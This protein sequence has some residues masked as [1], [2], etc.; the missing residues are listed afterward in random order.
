VVVVHISIRSSEQLNKIRT[1][2]LRWGLDAWPS[3]AREC[4]RGR[5]LKVKGVCY[6][7]MPGRIKVQPTVAVP[8]AAARCSPRPTG[9]TG[10]EPRAA[11][12]LAQHAR[13]R[14]NVS[15]PSE[16]CFGAARG[17]R[18]GRQS[19]S[20]PEK[21]RLQARGACH[22]LGGAAASPSRTPSTTITGWFPASQ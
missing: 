20:Q 12:H 6:R 1:E 2:A 21:G 7:T 22:T 16:P 14:P 8:D 19:M 11:E 5:Y 9:G 3:F 10:D 13:P 15:L 18:S 17:S 4:A